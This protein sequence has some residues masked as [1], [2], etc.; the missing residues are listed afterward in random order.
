MTGA[1]L[2]SLD[3]VWTARE[4]E[5]RLQAQIIAV[6]RL[7]GWRHV[8]HTYDSRRSQAGFPDLILLRDGRGFAIEVKV[9]RGVVR[10]TQQAWLDAFALVPGFE[11]MVARPSNFVELERKL[12]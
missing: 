9:E 6:A 7:R 12:R 5:A 3:H 8:Y 2:K 1:A 4:G 11:S 10:P